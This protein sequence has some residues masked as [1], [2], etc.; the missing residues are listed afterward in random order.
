MGNR[1][2]SS[3]VG[4]SY[5]S[6]VTTFEPLCSYAPGN[7]SAGSAKPEDRVQFRVRTSYTL[8]SLFVRVR[9]N[10]LD[11]G[12]SIVRS[13]INGADGSQSVSF[14]AGVTG[15]FQDTVNSDSLTAGDLVASQEIT[16]GT[17][18]SVTLRVISYSLN[19]TVGERNIIGSGS[20]P[21]LS[22]I[23]PS[24]TVYNPIV[25]RQIANNATEST[26]QYRIRAAITFSNL[27]VFVPTNTTEDPTIQLRINGANGNQSL[28]IP[29]DATGDF[30]DVTNTDILVS[31]DLVNLQITT[32]AG[33]M[34]TSGFW[35]SMSQL[36]TDGVEGRPT[37]TAATVGAGN[38]FYR[39][40]GASFN[41][42]A[43]EAGSKVI[44]GADVR[45]RN[46]YGLI[47]STSVTANRDIFLHVNGVDTD[48]GVT[49]PGS[50]TGEFEDLVSSVDIS[51]GDFVSHQQSGSGSGSLV[52]AV[53]GFIQVDI[54]APA[55]GR[56]FFFW[57]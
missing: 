52:K 20:Q 41:P 43:L 44:S 32:G 24:T 51:V 26:T 21:D 17:S 46:Y 35:Y 36:Q 39:I 8:A 37:A 34:H 6:G 1:I 33:T 3:D 48:L 54:P 27:R 10:S 9:I 4:G 31:G 19:D 25:G 2:V 13:R 53:L 18:G 57:F 29:T 14:G 15:D 50:T 30:E 47:T 42:E 16:G 45:A 55:A 22:G 12:T 7:V 23:A 11:T 40:E 56:A 49:V 5:G 28:A 38:G